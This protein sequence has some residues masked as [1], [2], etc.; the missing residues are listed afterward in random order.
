MSSETFPQERIS[1]ITAFH[2][3]IFNH[4]LHTA[5]SLT[6]D[7]TRSLSN[8]LIVPIVW[9]PLWD[10]ERKCWSPNAAPSAM[11]DW[12]VMQRIATHRHAE[13]AAATASTEST[14]KFEECKFVDS[15]VT[16]SYLPNKGAFYVMNVDHSQNPQSFMSPNDPQRYVD[17]IREKYKCTVTNLQQ[18]LLDVDHVSL[19]LNLLTNRFFHDPLLN[20]KNSDTG[21][22]KGSKKIILVPEM[23]IIHPLCAPYH[24]LSYML[25]SILYRLN[26]FYCAEQLRSTIARETSIGPET[27][28]K[29]CSMD[30][31]SQC[32]TVTV[33]ADDSDTSERA[34]V[35]S[36]SSTSSVSDESAGDQLSPMQLDFGQL[37]DSPIAE[38]FDASALP[39]GPPDDQLAQEISKAF[40]Q[41]FFP[42]YEP[43]IY[44]DK[45]RPRHDDGDGDEVNQ[46][47]VNTHEHVPQ[48][49]EMLTRKR[50]KLDSISAYEFKF[51]ECKA[52][53]STRGPS[54]SDILRAL[55]LTKAHEGYNLERLETVGDS[56]LKYA[57]SLWTFHMCRSHEGH[58]SALKCRQLSNLN[59][60]PLVTL[61][62]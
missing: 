27:F 49:G 43:S 29:W 18:P 12:S 19:H 56:F 3:Y 61:V 24:R 55:T 51:D 25:P 36:S 2:E 32:D 23:C 53:S 42:F 52:S 16:R 59:L 54:P 46:S 60:Y 62:T 57:V 38:P 10:V 48:F 31:R 21:A 28:G 26:C 50:Q 22:S 7:F 14:F 6:F 33:D 37:V 17:Y 45:A 44:S 13:A 39:S 35:T 8:Y 40:C 47:S 58:L 4:H 34:A 41:E 30:D 1:Q 20:R 15:V 9:E 5:D 11:I